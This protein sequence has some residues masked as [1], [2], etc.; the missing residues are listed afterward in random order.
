MR[1][2]CSRD[3]M[4]RPNS[5]R[6]HRPVQLTLMCKRAF[7][8]PTCACCGRDEEGLGVVKLVPMHGHSRRRSWLPPL[9]PGDKFF[10]HANVRFVGGSTAERNCT[11]ACAEVET[12]LALGRPSKSLKMHRPDKR[13]LPCFCQTTKSRKYPNPPKTWQASM[14]PSMARRFSTQL[15]EVP[16]RSDPKAC[17]A[18][19]RNKRSLGRAGLGS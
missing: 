15:P 18:I 10:Q 12:P 13:R 2:S 8:S 14:A 3:E 9:A 4:N 16:F 7:I 5:R 19:R 1:C 11:M 6:I 17:G